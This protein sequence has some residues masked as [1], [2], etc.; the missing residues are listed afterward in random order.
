LQSVFVIITYLMTIIMMRTLHGELLGQELVSLE[1][2]LD[3]LN[4][5]DSG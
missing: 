4:K 3:V 5:D 1:G 2:D